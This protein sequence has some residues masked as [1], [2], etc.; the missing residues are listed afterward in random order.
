MIDIKILNNIDLAMINFPDYP[1]H[2]LP[3]LFERA[4]CQL[5]N[6]KASQIFEIA[7]DLDYMLEHQA[8]DHSSLAPGDFTEYKVDLVEEFQVLMD[9]RDGVPWMWD[10]PQ[11]MSEPFP[12]GSDSEYFAVIAIYRLLQ[13]ID[14]VGIAGNSVA[15]QFAIE[16]TDAVCRAEHLDMLSCLLVD[17]KKK[18]KSEFDAEIQDQIKSTAQRVTSEYRASQRI[19]RIELAKKAA[20]VRYS[21]PNSY[22]KKGEKIRQI[23]ASGIYKNRNLCAL[24]E[25]E[26][27]GISYETARRHL[28]NT[29]EPASSC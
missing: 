29:P 28:R 11:P 26:T 7:K 1:F 8:K 6:R 4:T 21:N 3:V 17:E 16:A 14:W 9:R 15:G 20:E 10:V 24:M 25:C 12:Q 5:R 2:K 27:L 18:I 22:R 23:W 13:C 19:E